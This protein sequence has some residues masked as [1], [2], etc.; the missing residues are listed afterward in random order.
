[1]QQIL[2]DSKITVNLKWN[3]GK[4]NFEKAVSCVYLR[5]I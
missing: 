3:L 1:M 4:N 5:K 2:Q